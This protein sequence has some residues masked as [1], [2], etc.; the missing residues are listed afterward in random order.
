MVY[1]YILDENDNIVTVQVWD[2]KEKPELKSNPIFD[3]ID[4]TGLYDKYGNYLYKLKNGKIEKNTITLSPEMDIIDRI[5]KKNI[6]DILRIIIKAV[7]DPY[8][9][10]FITLKGEILNK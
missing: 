10:E 2:D 3:P 9:P 5:S 6:F 1:E 4:F 8:D 7:S